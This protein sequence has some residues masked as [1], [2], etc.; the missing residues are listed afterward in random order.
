MGQDT[1]LREISAPSVA[2]WEW[3]STYEDFGTYKHEIVWV[4]GTQSIRYCTQAP[5][6]DWAQTQISSPERFGFDGTLAG[7]RKCAHAFVAESQS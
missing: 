3:E 1:Q 6:R 7:A 5:G 2:A 4:R